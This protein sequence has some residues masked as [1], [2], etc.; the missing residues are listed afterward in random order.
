MGARPSRWL[1]KRCWVTRLDHRSERGIK[2]TFGEFLG[3]A[4]LTAC[5]GVHNS[6]GTHGWLRVVEIFTWQFLVKASLSKSRVLGSAAP[7]IPSLLSGTLVWLLLALFVISR[8]FDSELRCV[9]LG[10]VNRR[11]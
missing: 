3:R 1:E 5:F 10:E 6:P 7:G 11:S 9:A 4:R 8:G 2:N